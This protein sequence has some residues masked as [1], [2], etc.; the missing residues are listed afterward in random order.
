VRQFNNLRSANQILCGINQAPHF[1]MPHVG[2]PLDQILYCLLR[3]SVAFDKGLLLHV[4]ELEFAESDCKGLGHYLL[5]LG[6]GAI[7]VEDLNEAIEVNPALTLRI[8]KIQFALSA[9]AFL[10]LA[11]EGV[12]PQ[13]S[14]DL[15]CQQIMPSVFSGIDIWGCAK[16]C[17]REMRCESLDHFFF[18]FSLFW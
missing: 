9:E 8:L 13:G 2:E 15:L 1:L 14:P 11:G 16:L 7:A 6:Y 4:L 5:C 18:L 10:G 17:I 12:S 3:D